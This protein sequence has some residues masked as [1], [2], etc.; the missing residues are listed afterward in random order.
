LNEMSLSEGACFQ[1]LDTN[2]L[3]V[4]PFMQETLPTTQKGLCPC[5]LGSCKVLSRDSS[6]IIKQ[7]SWA[8]TYN[9]NPMRFQ[10]SMLKFMDVI[11]RIV[12]PLYVPSHSL[13]QV[14][15]L[16]ESNIAFCNS[17]V[18][19]SVLGAGSHV[20]FLS[21]LALHTRKTPFTFATLQVKVRAC[22]FV[23]FLT[24]YWWRINPTCKLCGD[25]ILHHSPC[26]LHHSKGMNHLGCEEPTYQVWVKGI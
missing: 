14:Q 21:Q 4:L 18:G 24:L 2:L 15:F 5:I 25:C 1:T 10:F 17:L 26:S 11:E 3:L 8:S 9:A 12:P 23:S 6:D 19:R 20:W 13:I 22:C 16:N 7:S